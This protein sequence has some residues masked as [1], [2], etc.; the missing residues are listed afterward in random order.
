VDCL[1]RLNVILP[2]LS[3][4]GCTHL[5]LARDVAVVGAGMTL[6]HHTAHADKSSRELFEEAA[7][8]SMNSVDSGI[9]PTDI[10]AMII[11]NLS[12][13]VFEHQSHTACLM[14][15][16]SGLRPKPSIRIETA[17]AS[18]GVAFQ[19]GVMA[20][21]SGVYDTILVGGV[22]KMTRLR[23]EEITD[24]LAMC[25][26]NAYEYPAGLTNPGL[27]AMMAV[28]HFKKYGTHWEQ[29]AAM[30]IKNHHNA[31][32]NPKAHFQSEIIDIAKKV[33]EKKGL[34]FNDPM[35]FLKSTANPM[36]A[37]PLRLF[38]CSPFGFRTIFCLCCRF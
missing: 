3:A 1:K 19:M 36:I 35:Q 11:G 37:Y 4:L 5:K 9:D 32:L 7:S 14:A 10:D 25:V 34:T 20:I 29:L 28:A 8:E 16:W 26:D 31:S 33:G 23:T 15:D 2:K 6:F 27:Y 13:D 17:C 12:S 38:G 21:A 24:A 18:S 22:E 30:A